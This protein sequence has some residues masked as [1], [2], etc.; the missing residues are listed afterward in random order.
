[1]HYWAVALLLVAAGAEAAQ[2]APAASS[3]TDSIRFKI[4]A[5]V[6]AHYRWS[7]DDRLPLRFP[8]DA[9]HLPQGQAQVFQQAVAPGSSF[10]V[11]NLALELDADFP[12][13]ITAHTRI[14][15]IDLH[16]RNPT[17][18]D[19]TVNVKEAWIRFGAK[20]EALEAPPGSSFYALFGK[21]PK[22]ERQ[23][24]RK[25]ESY[26]MVSTAFNRFEDIQLQL[27]GTLGKHFYFRT[28]VSNGNP[29]FFR[30]PNALAGDN[31]TPDRM[32]PA[33]D[34]RL[35]SGFLIFYHAE[36]EEFEIDDRPEWGGGLGVSFLS[37]DL[38]RGLDVMGFYYHTR[39]SPAA[40][41]RGTFYEGDLDL[42][43]GT[44]GISLPISGDRRT[45]YGANLD[46][47]VGGLGVFVQIVREEA[48]A[49]P[50][51]GFEVEAGYRVVRGDPADPNAL[52]TGIEPIVRYSRIDND[53]TAPS[54]FVA[55][56]VMWDW[57]KLDLGVRLTIRKGL[58]LT[59]EYAFHDIT[60]A[61]TIKHDE[62][63]TTLRLRF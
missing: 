18:S 17:S 49:L 43:D 25:L 28:Q 2:D 41:L 10:E 55:P 20:Y 37:E 44:G 63:L 4:G 16:N 57:A 35:G 7:E 45:E 24:A 39:L 26:G 29:T 62:F 9:S 34:P 21:A 13:A 40:R 3:D 36:A 51:T 38:R 53:F 61:R 42:L 58:D 60:A 59:A 6:K 48:A 23:R 50:R 15:F 52:F 31:G 33:P 56:S 14:N 30:D 19:Q 12:H 22:F 8:F 11:S 1:M 46:A 27:G 54:N 5:E 47:Q 32:P